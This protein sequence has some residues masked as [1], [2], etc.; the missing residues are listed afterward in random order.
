ML[1]KPE[2]VLKNQNRIIE[3]GGLLLKLKEDFADKYAAYSDQDR[4]WALEQSI[5]RLSLND[6]VEFEI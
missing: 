6:G 4:Q 5:M 1:I 3:F 2:K